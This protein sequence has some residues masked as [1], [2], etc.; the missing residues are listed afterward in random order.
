MQALR[1]EGANKMP[2]KDF[3]VFIAQAG[4]TWFNSVSDLDCL[5]LSECGLLILILRWKVIL[6]FFCFLK[7]LHGKAL[8]S[9]VILWAKCQLPG[10]NILAPGNTWV[11]GMK[12]ARGQALQKKLWLEK[13][14]HTHLLGDNWIVLT[15]RQSLLLPIL[16]LACVSLFWLFS[17]WAVVRPT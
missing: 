12:F 14:R 11:F 4:N 3:S 7:L 10:W 8:C 2:V 5:A 9:L 6:L 16:W 15:G 1:V 13:D 17:S